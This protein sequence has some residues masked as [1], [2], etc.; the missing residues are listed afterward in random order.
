MFDKNSFL[1]ELVEVRKRKGISK[2]SMA[3]LLH[4]SVTGINNI[5]KG[6]PS[7]SNLARYLE[8]LFCVLMVLVTIEIL[9]R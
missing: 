9:N 3:K 1:D 2:Y 4:T 7:L 6:N 8:I 5:E